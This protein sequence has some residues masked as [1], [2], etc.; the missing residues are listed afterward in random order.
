MSIAAKLKL[1]GQLIRDL[2]GSKLFQ[3]FELR[4][5]QVMSTQLNLKNTMTS[6]FQINLNV[7]MIKKKVQSGFIMN[8]I[9]NDLFTPVMTQIQTMTQDFN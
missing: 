8:F 2:K 7:T 1:E 9:A 5:F 4:T 6:W 3:D